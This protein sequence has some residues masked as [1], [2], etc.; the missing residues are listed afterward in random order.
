MVFK[1]LN[2]VNDVKQI[3]KRITAVYI[4]KQDIS[5]LLINNHFSLLCIFLLL[6]FN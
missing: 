3:V 4:L 2:N 5:D 1:I 6:T